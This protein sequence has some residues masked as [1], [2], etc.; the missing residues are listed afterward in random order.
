MDGMKGTTEFFEA[1]EQYYEHFDWSAEAVIREPTDI[2][3]AKTI[4]SEGRAFF[5]KWAHASK[6]LGRFGRDDR[7][8]F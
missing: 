6:K 8:K 7:A 2:R 5:K 3:P 4:L 1:L